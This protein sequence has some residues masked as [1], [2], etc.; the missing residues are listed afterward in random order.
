MKKR[1]LLA[2]LAA[3]CLYTA[4]CFVGNTF[5]A[6]RDTNFKEIVGCLII[7]MHSWN[8]LLKNRKWIPGF[9]TACF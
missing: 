6:S 7:L 1:K 5:A 9:H 8:L 3:A 4:T 2:G